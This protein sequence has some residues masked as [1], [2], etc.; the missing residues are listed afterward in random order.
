MRL[1]NAFTLYFLLWTFLGLV[2]CKN[3]RRDKVVQDNTGTANSELKVHSVSLTSRTGEDHLFSIFDTHAGRR[4]F[5]I[6]SSTGEISYSLS[7]SYQPSSTRKLDDSDLFN[8]E[9]IVIEEFRC[10]NLQPMGAYRALSESLRV[11]VHEETSATTS[12]GYESNT[13]MSSDFSCVVTFSK[14]DTGVFLQGIQLDP[15]AS[16]P[17]QREFKTVPCSE[18]EESASNEFN[19]LCVVIEENLPEDYKCDIVDEAFLKSAIAEKANNGRLLS[20]ERAPLP[21]QLERWDNCFSGMKETHEIGIGIAV[22]SEMVKTL[23]GSRKVLPYLEAIVSEVNVVFLQQLNIKL[24]VKSIEIVDPSAAGSV[25]WDNKNCE[26]SIFEQLQAFYKAGKDEQALWKLMDNCYSS[27]AIGVAVK[28]SLCGGAAAGVTWFAR[29]GGTWKIFAHEVGHI[30]GA[31]HSF[32]EGTGRTG[33]LM[34]YGDGRYNGEI[35]F[36]TK[37]RKEEMCGIIS[38]NLKCPHFNVIT[39]KVLQQ[40]GTCGNGKLDDGEECECDNGKTDCD[41]CDNCKLRSSAQ[42]SPFSNECCT[43][44]C[45]FQPTNRVCSHSD[46]PGYCR[47]GFCAASECSVMK[48]GNYCGIQNDA[49]PCRKR[50]ENPDTGYCSVAPAIFFS[51]HN[52]RYIRDG[53]FCQTAEV[54]HGQCFDG[55]CFAVSKDS[56]VNDQDTTPFPSEAPTDYPTPQETKFPTKF[57]TDLPTKFPTEFPSDFPTKFPTVYPTRSPTDFPSMFP[58][59]FP[60]VYPTKS[61]TSSPT[62][63]PSKAPTKFPTVSPTASPTNYPTAGVNNDKV[64]NQPGNSKFPTKYPTKQPTAEPTMFPTKFPTNSPTSAP[65]TSPT[66]FPTMNPTLNPTEFPTASPTKYP[67]SSVAED[68]SNTIV[69]GKPTP[70]PTKFPTKFPTVKVTTNS[71]S[72]NEARTGYPTFYPTEFP[73]SS[74]DADVAGFD[75]SSNHVDSEFCCDEL[76][77]LFGSGSFLFNPE[78]AELDVCRGALWAGKTC[79]TKVSFTEAQNTCTLSGARLCTA[80]ELQLLTSD[81]LGCDFTEEFIWSSSSCFL[82]DLK[83]GRISVHAFNEIDESS[84]SIST[85]EKKAVVCCAEAC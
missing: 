20:T 41:C 53:A 68:D 23:G 10:D 14:D 42:C 80:S 71:D 11:T 55:I 58:T 31:S 77:V 47:N 21:F 72:E 27:G 39:S 75:S 9:V 38:K 81:A 59:K 35:Q 85:E 25:S 13:L 56:A 12:I 29:N 19:E 6:D 63:F 33:G 46:G 40:S 18:T 7:L 30:F 79:S 52:L 74:F 62:Q 43:D 37:Y 34:D 5:D 76:Q 61:P 84:C 83:E 2:N 26:K 70:F 82:D 36:N 49:L 24:L 66:N 51:G 78:H 60:T 73:A 67:T 8:E 22:G 57:P 28:N 48:R 4:L 45:S 15:N 44:E 17:V 1:R 64:N 65:S 50:C 16:G 69:E 3:L 32:E 54:G